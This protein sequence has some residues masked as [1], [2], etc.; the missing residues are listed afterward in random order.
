[1]YDAYFIKY[2]NSANK[3]IPRNNQH[4][5]KVQAGHI[6][7]PEAEK[8]LDQE[9]QVLDKRSVR[10]ERITKR[11]SRSFVDEASSLVQQDNTLRK[12]KRGW[13]PRLR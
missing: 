3:L 10:L 12:C 2:V 8:L 6:I 5:M 7:V 11:C 9:I 4:F 1:V 13:K